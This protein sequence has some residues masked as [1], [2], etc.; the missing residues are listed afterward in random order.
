MASV[1]DHYQNHLAPVYAWMAGG[2]EAAIARGAAEI[3]ALFPNLPTGHSA[4]D[5]GAGFGMHAIP[6]A[7]RG[8]A[9][10]ALDTSSQLLEQL[11][12]G[13]AGLPIHPVL[14]DL[15]AF[16]KYL[17]S[18]PDAILC[19]GDTLT[20]L[21]DTAAV[22]TLATLAAQALR[23]GGTFVAS[24]RDYS[25]ASVGTAR[26]IPVK[27][28]ADRILTC[29]LEYQAESVDVHDLLHERRDT[30]WDF[31]VSVYRK[32][33]LLPSWVCKTFEGNGFAARLEPGLGGM[34][35]IVATKV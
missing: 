25:T 18:S 7:R 21:P 24:F 9:V 3:A 23:A 2:L 14:D 10:V 29:F 19:M 16:P 12:E 27:S 1:A 13:S 11:T 20:H 4:V 34:V 31:R 5:L 6:L 32:L 26:F 28:D 33:R 35:R 22:M 8:C 30:A 15:F 17:T